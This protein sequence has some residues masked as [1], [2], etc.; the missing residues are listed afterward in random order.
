[1]K[2]W[3]VQCRCTVHYA[4]TVMVRGVTLDQAL[5]KAVA[6]AGDE[7]E[8]QPLAYSPIFVD[9]VAQAEPDPVQGPELLIPVPPR[10]TERDTP[11]V[12]LI[13]VSHG[14]INRIWA[15]R[16]PIRVLVRDYDAAIHATDRSKIR[17]DH[18]GRSYV[19]T[20]WSDEFPVE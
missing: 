19:L 4:N 6:R 16:G 10:F 8:W 5:E 3:R 15:K 11:P 2:A 7:P 12:V 18:G 17:L 14:C 20:E 9:A 13:V 1:M